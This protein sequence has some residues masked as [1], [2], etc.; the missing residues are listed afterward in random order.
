M[1]IFALIGIVCG[2][3]GAAFN[4]FNGRLSRQILGGRHCEYFSFSQDAVSNHCF[5]LLAGGGSVASA[6]LV[7][8]A[9]SRWVH[10]DSNVGFPSSIT[11]AANYIAC[12]SLLN[13]ATMNALVVG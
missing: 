6:Q 12:Y 5:S 9:F 2:L 10:C 1:F 13:L 7:G 4:H 3:L 11:V 8:N